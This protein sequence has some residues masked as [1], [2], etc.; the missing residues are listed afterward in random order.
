MGNNKTEE[1]CKFKLIALAV[2]SG[3]V[4][5]FYVFSPVHSSA[6][7]VSSVRW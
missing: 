6:C 3:V 5:W 2:F 1:I 7:L 4:F